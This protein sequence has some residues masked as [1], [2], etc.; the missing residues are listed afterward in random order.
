MRH[1]LLTMLSLVMF[2]VF[3]QTPHITLN[4]T[5]I[6][7]A[8]AI[9]A[10]TTQTF[11]ITNTGNRDLNWNLKTR[12]V[13]VEFTKS[14]YAAWTLAANQDRVSS[15][16]WITRKDNQGIFNI[17]TESGFTGATSPANT[18]WAYGKSEELEPGDYTNWQ[19]AVDG[20]P[21][22]M[23][24]QVISMHSTA[25]DRYFDFTFHSFSGSNTGGGF[26]YTRIENGL[27]W[28]NADF[29]SGLILPGQSKTVTVTFDAGSLASGL[30]VGNL[31]IESN[32]PDF[33][34]K[35]ISVNLNVGQG[36]GT[37]EIDAVTTYNVG[38]GYYQQ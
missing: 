9:G 37:P 23:I 12:G 36:A 1:Y 6:S 26:S 28:I 31:V 35:T 25:D 34:E 19:T 30:Q 15:N 17:A 13:P 38:Q 20:T 3:A 10:T 2:N 32:D 14:P 7:T 18:L 22:E 5:S 29:T 21:Q 24:D 4:K 16:V 8:V 33:A 27:K 11:T